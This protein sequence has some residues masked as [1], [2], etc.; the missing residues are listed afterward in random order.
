VNAISIP[1]SIASVA[2]DDRQRRN[3]LHVPESTMRRSFWLI[4]VWM[5]FSTVSSSMQGAA[6]RQAAP[7]VAGT[8]VSSRAVF[9]KYC[10][11]CHNEKLKTAGLMLDTLDV[12]KVGEGAATWEKVARQLRSRSMP[13]VGMPRPEAATYDTVAGWL[14]TELDRAAAAAPNPGRL[15]A[16]QRLTRTEYRNAIRDLL[17]LEEFPKEMDFALLLPADNSSSGFDNLRD[18]LFVSET[19][20]EQYLSAARQIS[21]LAVGDPSVPQLLDTYV[22][23]T[24]LP[25]SSHVDGT[26]FGSRGGTI[27]RTTLPL[28]GEYSIEVETA[29]AVLGEQ[30]EVNVDGERKH[31]FSVVEPRAVTQGLV[32]DASLQKEVGTHRFERD[33]AAARAVAMNKGFNALIPMK[34]GQRE[35]I[36]T[37]LKHTSALSEDVVRRSMR[38]RGGQPG[39]A[40]VTIRGPIKASGPGETASRRR[41]FTC[42]PASQTDEARCARQILSTLV[43]RA[44][45]RPVTDDDLQT[46]L[47]F[48]QDGRAQGGFERGIQWALERVLISPEFLFRIE[49]DRRTATPYRVSDL[50]LAS[51]L[52]M[53]IWSSIPD[54]ELLTVAGQGRLE[55]PAVLQRQV[56]RMLAD[57]RSRSLV[58]NFA[59][60]WLF[61]RDLEVK[62]PNPR[63]F[64]DFDKGLQQDLEREADLFLDSV[65]REDRS[66]LDLLN[67]NYTFLNERLAVHYGIAGVYGSEFRRVPLD[68][69]SP[70][71]GLLGKGSILTLTS[72][73]TRTSPVLRGKYILDNLLGAPPPP[74]PPNVPALAEK[75]NDG[76]TT[77]TLREAMARHRANPVCA[78]CHARMDPLGFAME[79][80]DAVGQWRTRAESGD[81]LDVSA[82]L[83]DGTKFDGIAGLR[84]ALVQ[85]P[86][87]FVTTVTE[88]LLMYGLGR[89][90]AYYD[91]PAIRRIV[92][93]AAGRDYRFSA[94]VL[95]VVNSVPF[96]MRVGPE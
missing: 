90:T 10:V 19:Q 14:E 43:R 22:L 15:P 47:P 93:E 52:S 57:R 78:S 74:P 63:L 32:T 18:L 13:P 65:L 75:A 12:A 44:Y 33:Q 88:K 64:R 77:L 81:T 80:F 30:F 49:A 66:V 54:D 73:A 84:E 91:A 85:R 26:P 1:T 59:A 23:P 34:A 17:A 4:A 36:V 70:R 5:A 27:I 7:S 37:F 38:G 48:Y 16:F 55:D 53:F 28:D 51:R 24:D 39:I 62:N 96:Q 42:R 89:K 87:R 72:Y 8:A 82:A 95:G 76:K 21:R 46:L 29:G 11:T 6:P 71:R 58:T 25:Q 67:A 56:L 61:L 41:L 3:E 40:S 79:N 9:D 45:R 50:E 2:L 35:I 92:R 60:Q 68:A 31:L 69:D 83:P 20:L 86:E 94:L